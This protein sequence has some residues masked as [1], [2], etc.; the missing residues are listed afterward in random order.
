MATEAEIAW[1]AGIFEGEGCIC[2]STPTDGL[3]G[4]QRPQARLTVCMTDRDVLERFLHVIGRGAINDK[5]KPPMYWKPHYKQQWEW[6]VRSWPDVTAV[7]ALLRP[8]L[9]GRRSQKADEI[10]ARWEEVRELRC[11]QCGEAFE[12]IRSDARYCGNRCKNRARDARAGRPPLW[13]ERACSF[14][15]TAYI[16]GGQH[17]VGYCSDRCRYLVRRQRE[18]HSVV[19]EGVI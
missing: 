5:K 11:E 4:K 19:G 12:S 14:C 2:W 9:C 7:L 13:R 17:A 16:G 3:P 18:G 10:L 1:A 6:S 8:W 15:G